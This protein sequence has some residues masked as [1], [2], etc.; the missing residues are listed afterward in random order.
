VRERR[1]DVNP[2]R[3]PVSDDAVVALTDAFPAAKPWSIID[4]SLFVAS[5]SA[6]AALPLVARK[7]EDSVSSDV[8][9]F[10]GA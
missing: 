1:V 6:G 5:S 4:S 2:W 9:F 8:R 7:R 3:R 10:V